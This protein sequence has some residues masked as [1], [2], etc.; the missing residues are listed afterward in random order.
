[1]KL[2]K[3]TFKDILGVLC[4]KNYVKKRDMGEVLQQ[5]NEM[6]RIQGNKGNWDYDPYMHGMYNGMELIVSI[7][8]GREP[9]FRNAPEAWKKDIKTE[10]LEVACETK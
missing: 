10:P 5:I 1:M 8:E 9:V 2:N 7:V 3:Y 4:L 6:L